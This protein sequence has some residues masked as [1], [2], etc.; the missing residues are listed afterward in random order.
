[1]TTALLDLTAEQRLHAC[2]VLGHPA[3]SVVPWHSL[4]RWTCRF[5]GRSWLYDQPSPRLRRRKVTAA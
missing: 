1:M 5:C 2:M 4:H 3:S